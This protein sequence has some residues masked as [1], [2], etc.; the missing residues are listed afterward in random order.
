MILVL[1]SANDA[2]ANHVEERLRARGVAFHRF[3]PARFPSKARLSISYS[4]AGRRTELEIDNE[5]IDLD[6][7]GSIWYRRPGAPVA[8]PSI[9]DWA[10][11]HARPIVAP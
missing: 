10:A 11:S 4:G 8:A 6:A 9:A 7:V 3:D 5:V 2:H 1:S